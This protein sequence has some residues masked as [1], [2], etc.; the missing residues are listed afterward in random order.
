MNKDRG[1]PDG[2]AIKHESVVRIAE[3]VQSQFSAPEQAAWG[4]L[5]G[6]LAQAVMAA[7]LKMPTQ[8]LRRF[9]VTTEEGARI[10][11]ADDATLGSAAAMVRIALL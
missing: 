11:A 10:A 9:I 5:A 4:Q 6:S 3:S 8:E 7:A 2:L 1:V